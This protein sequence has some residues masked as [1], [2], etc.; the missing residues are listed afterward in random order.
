MNGKGMYN[1]KEVWVTITGII[2][3]KEVFILT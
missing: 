3:K 1:D 2:V